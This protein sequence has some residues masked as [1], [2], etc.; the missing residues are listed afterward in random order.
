MEQIKNMGYYSSMGYH[1]QEYGSYN[2]R[3]I[4]YKFH[5]YNKKCEYDI[6]NCSYYS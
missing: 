1:L 4:H 2:P 6:F 3:Q 5:I